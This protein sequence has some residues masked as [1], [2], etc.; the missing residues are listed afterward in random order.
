[1]KKTR[2]L[3]NK[4][5]TAGKSKIKLFFLNCGRIF[6]DMAKLCFGSLVLGTVIRGELPQETLIMMGIIA[7]ATGA[8]FGIIIVTICEEK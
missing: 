4:V 8:L 7:T 2:K 5:G 3:A 6:I 1:M